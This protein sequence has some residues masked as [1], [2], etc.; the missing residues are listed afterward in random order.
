MTISMSGD[1][2]SRADIHMCRSEWPLRAQSDGCC[3][4]F[5]RLVFNKSS[6]CGLVLEQKCHLGLDLAVSHV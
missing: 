3:E 1:C 6:K 2:Y 5:E 4:M